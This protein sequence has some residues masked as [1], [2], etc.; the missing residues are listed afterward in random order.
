VTASVKVI[1]RVS[2]VAPFG[3]QFWDR[4]TNTIVRDGL[5]VMLYPTIDPRLRVMAVPNRSG[6]HVLHG[7]PGLAA[8]T[9]GDGGDAYWRALP[10][11]LDYRCEVTDDDARFHPFAVDVR[12]PFRGL[13]NVAC[14]P[15]P[16]EL[17]GRAP[18][19][20]DAI[21][22]FSAPTRTA[23]GAVAIV[24]AEL[25]DA[26]DG[27]PC[28]WCRLTVDIDGTLVGDAIAD[29]N[30]KALALFAFPEP[31]RPSP[32]HASPPHASPPSGA[33]GALM[34]WNA[35][36][37]A[38]H[39]RDLEGADRPDYCALLQQ[40]EVTLLAQRSP[41]TPLGEVSI[42]LGRETTVSSTADSRLL[43]DHA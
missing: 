11:A 37:R 18:P 35:H 24:R 43:V 8:A 9:W 6:V 38:Y 41:P 19:L 27:K 15:S 4:V 5:R 13:L 21:E 28:A 40:P 2:R 1:D 22:L 30:G 32:P 39:S 31:A 36:L 23:P 20:E 26:A 33:G 7:A 12:L 29:Q 25:V 10:A 16:L 3:V 17:D 14:A 34:T 42:P